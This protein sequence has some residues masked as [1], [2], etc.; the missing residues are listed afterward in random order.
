MIQKSPEIVAQATRI[1]A[2]KQDLGVGGAKF[3]GSVAAL[4]AAGKLP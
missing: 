3:C 1:C 2:L 4:R